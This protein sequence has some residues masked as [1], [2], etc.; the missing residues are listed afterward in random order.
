MAHLMDQNRKE[1]GTNPNQDPCRGV[2]IALNS[3]KDGNDPEEGMDAYRYPKKL[4][5]QVSL[6]WR[7]FAY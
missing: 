3:H 2:V 7:G 6:R 4:K 1:D 5:V